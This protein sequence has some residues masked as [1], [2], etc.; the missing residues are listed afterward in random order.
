MSFNVCPMLCCNDRLQAVNI[1]FIQ[2][3]RPAHP[4]LSRSCCLSEQPQ[5]LENLLRGYL[6]A[7]GHIS[8]ASHRGSLEPEKRP[9]NQFVTFWIHEELL[10]LS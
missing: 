9:S 6:Y 5:F 3:V 1:Y 4:F 7:E 8:F 2:I 10:R